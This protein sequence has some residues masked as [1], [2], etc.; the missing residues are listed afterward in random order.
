MRQGIAG[1]GPALWADGAVRT[2]FVIGLA[3]GGIRQHLAYQRRGMRSTGVYGAVEGKV[4]RGE[5]M[6]PGD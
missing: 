1:G 6:G 3:I 5:Q 2:P 4:K